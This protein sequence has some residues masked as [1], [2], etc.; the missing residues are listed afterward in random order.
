MKQNKPRTKEKFSA[1]QKLAIDRNMEQN[2]YYKGHIVVVPYPSQGHINPLLQFAKRLASKGVKATI[3]TTRYTVE[4]ICAANVGVEPISDGFDE[5]GF[6]EAKSEEVFLKSFKANGSSTLSQV[7]LKFRNT[8]SPVNCIVYDSFLPWALDVAR[9]HGIYGAAFFTNS[10]TVS[11][12]F[13]RIHNGTLSLPLEEEN[14]PLSSIAGVPPLNFRDLPSFLRLPESY[15]VYLAMKL[16]QFSNLEKADWV[17]AN[18]F[19]ELEPGV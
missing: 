12:I 14:M 19:E 17:F 8:H 2:K 11:S 3:A 4:S 13:C 16:S 9:E 5:G 7:I 15:P 10:A 18:T 1:R 6:A